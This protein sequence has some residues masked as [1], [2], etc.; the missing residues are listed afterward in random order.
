ML[1]TSAASFLPT[2]LTDAQIDELI[3]H[4]HWESLGP[5]IDALIAEIPRTTERAQRTTLLTWI[6]EQRGVASFEDLAQKLTGK[7]TVPKRKK[8]LRQALRAMEKLFLVNIVNFPGEDPA[9]PDPDD[10]VVGKNSLVS[11]T[12]TGMLWLRRAWSARE[13]LARH[14]SVEAVHRNLVAEEDETGWGDP[15]WVERVCTVDPEG[16]QGRAH[17][18]LE[19]FP[20]IA[21]I[22]DLADRSAARW[23][24]H[25][26]HGEESLSEDDARGPEAVRN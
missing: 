12:W 16:P 20:S 2:E 8:H 11:L 24:R 18:V 15:Y 23:S 21:S 25:P 13:R 9:A 10:D 3:A 17:R 5:K 7:A 22:F 26:D 14:G 1:P 6:Y 19:A 4:P